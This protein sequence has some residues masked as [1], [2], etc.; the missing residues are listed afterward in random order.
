MDRTGTSGD[1]Q[2]KEDLQKLVFP[3][4]VYYNRKRQSFRTEKANFNFE[5]IASIVLFSFLFL[6]L[7]PAG[8]APLRNKNT[9]AT[10]GRCF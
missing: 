2:L 4:G 9:P 10:A 6:R 3:E 1:I 7:C 5:Q 8:P